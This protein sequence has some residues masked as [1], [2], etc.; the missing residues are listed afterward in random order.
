[1]LRWLE[2]RLGWL[3]VPNVT[4][5][6]VAAQSLVFVL[7]AVQPDIWVRLPLIPTAVV[8]G[9]VWRLFTF[10]FIV[11]LLDPTRPAA[12]FTL[13]FFVWEMRLIYLFGAALENH[14]GVFRFNLFLLTGYVATLA[15]AALGLLL[16]GPTAAG[17]YDL[18]PRFPYYSLFLN[19]GVF[20]AFAFLYPDYVL[21]LFGILP[22]KVKWL[23]LIVW[24]GYAVYMVVGS[25]SDRLAVVGGSLHFVLFFWRDLLMLTRVGVRKSKFAVG[26]ATKGS[27]EAFHKCVVCGRTEVSHPKLEFRYDRPAPGAG[28][29]CYCVEHLPASDGRP[30]AGP[31]SAPPAAAPRAGEPAGGGQRL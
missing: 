10:P 9:E 8:A 29:Q 1:M 22:I 4:L 28:V 11:P 3:A 30:P 27:T 24:I 26:S 23:G 14:W 12:I 7:V 13:L 19:G 17:V 20:L 18:L 16:L 31:S 5:F 2:K 21:N 25:H 6:I 15:V